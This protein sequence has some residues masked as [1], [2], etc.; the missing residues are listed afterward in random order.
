MDMML[1]ENYIDWFHAVLNERLVHLIIIAL[2][3]SMVLKFL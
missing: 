2:L 3:F 1:I